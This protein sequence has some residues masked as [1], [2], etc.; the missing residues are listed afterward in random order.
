LIFL[1]T[2]VWVASFSDWHPQHKASR[3]LLSEIQREDL[4]CAAH[5]LAEVYATLTRLP[6][7]LRAHPR[8]AMQVLERIQQRAR[9]IS[10]D[11]R[12]YFEAMDAIGRRGIVGA[13]VYDALLLAC[14]RK[15]SAERIYTWNVR[16]FRLVAPDLAQRIVTPGE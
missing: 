8:S 5:S 12:E 6:G 14:A 7:E 13:F 2:S 9:V 10:L 3:F 11:A 15:A 1:D 16:H 4:A